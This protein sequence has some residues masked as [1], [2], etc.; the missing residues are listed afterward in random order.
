MRVYQKS[1][2]GKQNFPNLPDADAP[3]SPHPRETRRALAYLHDRGT[4]FV[5]L[6]DKKPLWKGYL[7]RRPALETVLHSPELGIV[8][9]SLGS[10][11]L[12]V[13][14]GEPVQLCLFHPPLVV[15]ASGQDGRCHLYYRDTEPR[16]N[17]NWDALGCGG[18][19]RGA[20]GFLRLWHPQS[21]VNLLFALAYNPNPCMFP[22]ELFQ[23]PAA[24]KYRPP[25]EP[26]EPFTRQVALPAIDLGRVEPGSRNNSL[27]D[28]VRFW[29]Y[30]E[31]KPGDM[32][33][34]HELVRV[35]AQS[36]NVE[37]K[38]PLPV[39]EVDKLALSVSTWVWSGGGPT[40]H[41]LWTQEDRRLGG[42]TWGRMRRYDNRE[43]DRAVVRAVR[44]G[45][46]KRS[47]ARQFGLSAMQVS[48]IVRRDEPP[49]GGRV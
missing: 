23:A 36:R 33:E 32:H 9:W 18:Q 29:S 21:A 28:V 38:R 14:R 4:H 8:P 13:D 30:A 39:N 10:T 31:A 15:L 34:W 43:R 16:R 47:V 37:F 35:Y 11:A 46:S 3:A 45:R 27:F 26:G 24:K 7:K 17:G 22:A 40:H 44:G 49:F 41:R 25:A 20:N 19:I 48:R 1:P 6:A 42:L 2:P 5:L 12:D